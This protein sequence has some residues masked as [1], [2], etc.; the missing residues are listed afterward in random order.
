MMLGKREH[1]N[2]FAKDMALERENAV[3]TSCVF[4]ELSKKC[5][6]HSYT[7]KKSTVKRSSPFVNNR[8][9]KD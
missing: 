9:I 3:Q 2:R 5:R 4:A 6:F 1:V 8:F 7:F